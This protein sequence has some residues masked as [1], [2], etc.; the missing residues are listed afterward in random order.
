MNDARQ[1]RDTFATPE[2]RF[3]KT[4]AVVD[5][6]NSTGMKEQQPQASWLSSLGWL[7][8]MTTTTATRAVPEV[9]I[10]Y[11]GDGIMMVCGTD[12]ATEL[13][14]A[15]IQIQEEV[16][17]A[18][19]SKDGGKGVIDFTV[20][21]GVSTG[22]V[23]AFTTPAGN[24][25]FVGSVVDKAFRLSAA[26]NANA[27][28]I[29]TQTLGAANVM[30]IVSR[31]GKA[32]RRQPEEYI[33]EVQ[34]AVLKGF[35]QPVAYH[36]LMWGRQ[37]Y[38]VTSTTV[39]VSTE[40]LRTVPD[41]PPQ[42]APA[43]PGHPG[44]AERHRGEVT[45]WNAD[46]E[47]GFVREPLTGEEFYLSSRLMVYRDD[48]GKLTKGRQVAFVAVGVA[49]GKR[50]RQAGA[51]LLVDEPAEG[52]LVSLPPNKSYGWIRIEDVPGNRHLVYVPASE[53][54]GYTLGDSLSFTVRASD[55]GAIAGELEKI[56]DEAA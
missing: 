30:R 55:K 23:I 48:I 17:T 5:M 21:A 33:G 12:H 25:D 41:N 32:I 24:P 11:A 44:R 2:S 54:N 53:L 35:G 22:E 34:R 15:V 46:Q 7:Y 40:R 42:A 20:S 27:I 31:F 13:L 9:V 10:K 1:L 47:Y 4:V 50:L 51:T 16:D 43:R 8:D 26:A 52:P 3:Q 49:E 28:F 45:F 38:G 36:E 19:A 14:N 56:E 39:T 6:V 29:D 18:G 37:L